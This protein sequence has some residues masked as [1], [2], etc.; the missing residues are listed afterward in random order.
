MSP[1]DDCVLWGSFTIAAFIFFVVMLRAAIDALADWRRVRRYLDHNRELVMRFG[2][3]ALCRCDGCRSWRRVVADRL[4][5]RE[6][7]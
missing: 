7:E 1:A 6:I 3:T 2:A 4:Y 5:R